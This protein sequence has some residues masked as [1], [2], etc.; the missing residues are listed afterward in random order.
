MPPE[1]VIPLQTKRLIVFPRVIRPGDR[2]R[3]PLG[4]VF[5]VLESDGRSILLE[6]HCRVCGEPFQTNT[7]RTS[8]GWSKTCPGHHRP[9]ARQ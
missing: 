9:G 7:R 6:G 4:D 1:Y 5:T 2:V 3:D 8:T